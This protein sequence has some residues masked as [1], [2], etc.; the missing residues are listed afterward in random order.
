[1]GPRRIAEPR[2]RL[3]P[4]ALLAAT[5]LPLAGCAGLDDP[6]TSR[7]LDAYCAA[8][9]CFAEGSA[10]RTSGVTA[11]ATAFAIGPAAGQVVLGALHPSD[12]STAP[13]VELL[14]RGHGSLRLC[15][16]A[17]ASTCR[18]R[19][20]AIPSEPTWIELPSDGTAT[21]ADV[22]TAAP[23]AVQ[24]AVSVTGD[25]SSLEL[26]DLRDRRF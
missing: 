12:A 20:L 14:V 24:T 4:L 15:T 16:C 17:T 10:R 2:V 23:F 25:G 3:R 21:P 11:D 8:N 9:L 6:P 7:A 22:T 5:S 13:G 19:T 1:M 18:C 26:L